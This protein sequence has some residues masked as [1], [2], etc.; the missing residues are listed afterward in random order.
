MRQIVISPKSFLYAILF[1]IILVLSWEL[2]EVILIFFVAFILNAGLRPVVTSLEKL[3]ISRAFAITLV[4]FLVLLIVFILGFIVVRELIAQAAIFSS[5][6]DSKYKNFTNF[7]RI[8]LPFLQNFIALENLPS[9]LGELGKKI[10]ELI[11]SSNLTGQIGDFFGNIGTQGIRIANSTV[12]FIFNFFI[13]I[14]LSVY[15]IKS[16]KN[17]HEGVFNLVP[18]KVS[19]NLSRILSKIQVSLG[20][21]LLG[22]GALML[23]IGIASYFIVLIPGFFDSNY[24]VD[25]YALIIAI[26]AG[27]LELV[28]NIGPTITLVL[29][30]IIAIL[31]GGS[32]PAI[33]YIVA[34]FTILQ[35]AE[36][37][38]IVPVVMKKAVDLHP[39]VSILGVL[40]G[41]SLAGPIGGLLSMPVIGALQIVAVELL[42]EWKKREDQVQSLGEA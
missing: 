8:N 41:F 20:S 32:V 17:F 38:L 40:A 22:Q 29:S 6:L 1:G 3:K 28:P 25:N 34:S 2:R 16:R 4:Y 27:F 21:W 31:S 15:M 26:I 12:Q 11:S 9:D 39:I 42:L 10:S 14:I 18:E 23:V 5:D 30:V 13:I 33:I 37:L 24:T 35:Q 19:K 7:I 36:S